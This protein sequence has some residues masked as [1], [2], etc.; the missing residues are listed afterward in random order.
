MNKHGYLDSFTIGVYYA[1]ILGVICAPGIFM[2][3]DGDAETSIVV[4]MIIITISIIQDMR[5]FKGKEFTIPVKQKKNF[6]KDLNIALS[7]NKHLRNWASV[8]I[9][10]GNTVYIK[11]KFSSF[12]SADADIT[13]T[14]AI[15]EDET[16]IITGPRFIVNELIAFFRGKDYQKASLRT[17]PSP[18]I[19]CSV[20]EQSISLNAVACPHCGEPNE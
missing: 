20:C 15:L 14:K 7:S 1:I 9:E 19:K 18:L 2:F 6:L 4:L 10:T 12:I 11:M 16:A 13:I 17:A 5:R 3:S 8:P